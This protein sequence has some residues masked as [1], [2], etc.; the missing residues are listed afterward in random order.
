[1]TRHRPLPG[2]RNVVLLR[3]L[4]STTAARTAGLPAVNRAPQRPVLDA[5]GVPVRVGDRVLYAGR[6]MLKRATVVG[7]RERSRWAGQQFRVEVLVKQLDA[8]GTV[9]ILHHPKRVLVLT[10]SAAN[11]RQPTQENKA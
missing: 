9:S 2:T 3:P 1:M 4:P 7:V 5:D 11:R 10:R 8:R 6:W